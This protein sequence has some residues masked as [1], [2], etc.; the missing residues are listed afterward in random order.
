MN[1]LIAEL[2]SNLISDDVI[3]Y[4]VDLLYVKPFF[5]NELKFNVKDHIAGVA[6]IGHKLGVKTENFDNILK[7]MKAATKAYHKSKLL[8]VVLISV[9]GLVVLGT[10]GYLA[11]PI[12]AAAIGAAAGL[13][14]AAA[15]SFGLAFLGGGSLAT[16]GAGMAGGLWLVTGTGG[17][18]GLG[19]GAGAGIIHNMGASDLKNELIKLEITFKEVTLKNTENTAVAR[20]YIIEL[21]KAKE[22]L[23]KALEKAKLVN[24]KNSQ[25][26]KSYKEKLT[27]VEKA[28]TRLT[29]FNEDNRG[30]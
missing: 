5:P 4:I 11:A 25:T 7:T 29:K 18:L 20:G 6:K 8:K 21:T 27:I 28:I 24:D 1:E 19:A 3:K 23:Q 30:L 17:V 22:E 12:I 2:E 15:T 14:G 10:G 9:G 13:S 16:G 26:I